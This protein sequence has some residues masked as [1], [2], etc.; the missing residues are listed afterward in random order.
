MNNLTILNGFL[1]LIFGF[2]STNFSSNDST[3]AFATQN[4]LNS[5]NFTDESANP[6]YASMDDTDKRQIMTDKITEMYSRY[7]QYRNE[8]A[9]VYISQGWDK[10]NAVDNEELVK[11]ADLVNLQEAKALFTNYRLPTISKVGAELAHKFWM[12]V[13][14]SNNDVAFQTQILKAMHEELEEDDI[15]A[16]DYAFLADRIRINQGE[17]QI[18]G[19]QVQYNDITQRFEPFNLK[20]PESVDQRRVIMGL[21]RI[22][23]YINEVNSK[24][25]KPV[26]RKI[27]NRRSD[28]RRG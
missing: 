20:K 16:A 28:R 9:S 22:Q 7:K 3:A 24:F 8:S 25:K 6:D 1:I 19:T 10:S 21:E 17:N 23:T 13:L 12:I 2:F 4:H 15:S 14:N 18:Y 27:E 11:A 5:T 26:K